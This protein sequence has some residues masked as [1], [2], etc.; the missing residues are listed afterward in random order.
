ME[1]KM[2]KVM[3]KCLLVYL[4]YLKMLGDFGVKCIKL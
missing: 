4:C 3:V 2:F 1:K